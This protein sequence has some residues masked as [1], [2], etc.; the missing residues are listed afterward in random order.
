MV[1]DGINDAPALAQADVGIAMGV[2]G[3][4]AAIEAAYVALMRDD[5]RMV[6]EA[7]ALGRRAFRVIAQNL[8]FIAAYNA[9]GILLAATGWLPPVGSA[10]AQSLPM[11]SSCLI[12]CG[13]CGAVPCWTRDDD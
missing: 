1:G 11:S 6:P 2:A 7:I 13:F 5:W 3:T 8:W 10:A 9:V 12:R 4:D